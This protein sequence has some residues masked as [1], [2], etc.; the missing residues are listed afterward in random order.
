MKSVY[1]GCTDAT[2]QLVNRQIKGWQGKQRED[3]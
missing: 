2:A 3:G 1:S